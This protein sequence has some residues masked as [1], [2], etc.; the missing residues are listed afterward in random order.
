MKMHENQYLMSLINIKNG[1][2]FF[3]VCMCVCISKGWLF[4]EGLHPCGRR[5]AK[6]NDNFVRCKNFDKGVWRKSET[7]SM[8]DQRLF[9]CS[10]VAIYPSDCMH[11]NEY[12]LMLM[13]CSPI[14]LSPS[15]NILS[16]I[17]YLNWEKFSW[18]MSR[19]K[20]IIMEYCRLFAREKEWDFARMR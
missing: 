17:I 2:Y 1:W 8:R 9:L 11:V 14:L 12:F 15:E 3:P 19:K 20:I 5:K 10:P 16:V 6:E 4:H 13:T 18:K 7:R